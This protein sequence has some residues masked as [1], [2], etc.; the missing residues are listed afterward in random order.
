MCLGYLLN[1]S[2]PCWAEVPGVGLMMSRRGRWTRYT[3]ES[4]GVRTAA[5]PQKVSPPPVFREKGAAQDTVTYVVEL[6]AC[7]TGLYA[8]QDEL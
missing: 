3:S 4:D 1:E 2:V 8:G 6:G 5:C 7:I